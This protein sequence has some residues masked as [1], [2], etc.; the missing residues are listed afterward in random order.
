LTEVIQIIVSILLFFIMFFG[1]SFILNMLLRR[2]WFMSLI[3]PL[4][5]IV[6]VDN[7]S[8]LEYVK[9]PGYAFPEAFRQIIRITP[10]DII[11]LGAG[12]AGTIVSAIVIKMLR[13]NGYQMF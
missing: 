3:Y 8:T 6:I 5:V 1:I 10:V 11:I 9:N 12:F 2:T 4:I 7:M 13:R